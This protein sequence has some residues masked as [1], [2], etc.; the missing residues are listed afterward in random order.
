MVPYTS[1]TGE[2]VTTSKNFKHLSSQVSHS[3][4]C[5]YALF[6]LIPF[7]PFGT[8]GR[9]QDVDFEKKKCIMFVFHV[10]LRP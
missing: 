3:L 4:I 6:F 10:S 1:G 9:F 8:D 2:Q 7:T 5:S